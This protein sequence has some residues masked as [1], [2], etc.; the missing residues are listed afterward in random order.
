MGFRGGGFG[1]IGHGGHDESRAHLQDAP[2][3]GFRG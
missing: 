1:L 3:R 2:G